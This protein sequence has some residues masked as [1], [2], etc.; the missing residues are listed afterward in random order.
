MKRYTFSNLKQ[1]LVGAWCPSVSGRGLVLPDLSGYN[2]HGVLTNM[3]PGTDWMA[4]GNGLALDFD[5]SNDYVSLKKQNFAFQRTNQFSVSCIFNARS[6]ASTA[7]GIFCDSNSSLSTPG[8][9]ILQFRRAT[10]DATSITFMLTADDA[11]N[12]I[13]VNIGASAIVANTAYHLCAVYNGS[14]LAS[15]VSLFLNGVS[16]S[17]TV[18][19]DNLSANID[20]SS[21]FC[22]IGGRLTSVGAVTSGQMFN[23]QLD[24]IRIYS[25]EL[26]PT[27]IQQL[28]TGGRGVGLAPERIKHRRKTT[29]AA[30]NRRRRILIGASQ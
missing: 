15:G 20:Y 21:T 6:L 4:S 18:V 17:I 1:G 12:K 28:Y 22:T 19:Q 14:S 7:P 25:R 9:H 29:A 13:E 8:L 24:D 30:F 26:T 23:G 2:N 16:R 10:V 5:G 27:E 3:D 11:T